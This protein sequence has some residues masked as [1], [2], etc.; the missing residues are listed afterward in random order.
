MRGTHWKKSD[1]KTV[2]HRKKEKRLE[3]VDITRRK[4]T[5]ISL[6]EILCVFIAALL[7]VMF[8]QNTLSIRCEVSGSSMEP[9]F[10]AAG[11]S[12]YITRMVKPARGDVII[13]RSA[14]TERSP[15]ASL[16]GGGGSAGEDMLFIK[17]LIAL[18]GDTVRFV[19]D[20]DSNSYFIML[21]PADKDEFAVLNEP[22]INAPMT[23]SKTGGFLQ[24]K[25][26]DDG[27]PYD[28]VYFPAE[29]YGGQVREMWQIT[30]MEGHYF[31]LG[32]NRNV[33]RDCRDP[34]ILPDSG[35]QI[36]FDRVEGK[37]YMRLKQGDTWLGVAF[38]DLPGLW[39]ALFYKNVKYAEA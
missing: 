22:Y 34:S 18:P 3:L 31:A 9:N 35:G 14:L 21:K 4:K 15:S 12:V 27:R 30:V 5:E 19:S 26:R 13:F 10:N 7:V 6:W 2:L 36:P 16:F 28:G 39:R 20:I 8:L 17:R 38:S 33:S 24:L 11:D 1:N 29:E 32:D 23:Y 37:A 25:I